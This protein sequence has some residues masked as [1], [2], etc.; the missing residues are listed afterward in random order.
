MV[1]Y[2]DVLNTPYECTKI[3]TFFDDESTREKLAV[4]SKIDVIEDDGRNPYWSDSDMQS[5]EDF[6]QIGKKYK[7]TLTIEEVR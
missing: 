1:L 5:L 7:L 4:M 6:L 3:V 2:N